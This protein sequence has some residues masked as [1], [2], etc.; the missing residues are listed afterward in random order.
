MHI[1]S[2]K[3]SAKPRVDLTA[4]GERLWK[5]ITI[6]VIGPQPA[7]SDDKRVDFKWYPRAPAGRGYSAADI[8]GILDQCVGYLEKKYPQW[9]FRLV[10]LGPNRFNMVWAGDRTVDEILESAL[11]IKPA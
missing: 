8:Q 3:N 4:S 5:R 2:R 7:D 11:G 9:E 6:R 10:E 1:P